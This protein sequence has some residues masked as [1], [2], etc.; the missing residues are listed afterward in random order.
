MCYNYKKKIQFQENIT[1]HGMGLYIE[2]YERNPYKNN[3]G[4]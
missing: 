4:E 1:A 3:S 2:K